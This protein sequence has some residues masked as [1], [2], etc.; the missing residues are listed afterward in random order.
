MLGVSL[1]VNPR[2]WSVLFDV[3]KPVVHQ[4]TCIPIAAVQLLDGV[5]G[6]ISNG[7]NSVSVQLRPTMHKLWQIS[8]NTDLA[9]TENTGLHPSY[10]CSL[11][12]LQLVLGTR[13]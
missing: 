10:V 9:E 4:M 1:E 2:C 3:L 11:K 5:R 8:L 13:F 6:Y 12:L 7:T